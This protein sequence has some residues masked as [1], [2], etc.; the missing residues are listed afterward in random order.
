M[1]AYVFWHVAAAGTG[2]EDYETRL[3][4]FHAALRDDPSPG[5]GATAT[6]GLRSVP[7]LGD[8]GG[9]EDWYLVEDWAALGTLNERAVAAP[10]L[11]PHDAVAGRA[12]A[13]AG[14]VFLLTGG[15]PDFG[16]VAAATF[17]SSSSVQSMAAAAA[18]W[19]MWGALMNR[20]CAR[21]STGRTRSSGSS[22]QPMRQPVMLQYLLKLFTTTAEGLYAA[23]LTSGTSP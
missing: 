2:R 4:G 6:F 3:A 7:W 5:L 16:A 12:D 1:L 17:S 19:A 23:A 10:H 9:Y 22:S 18:T 15:T 21:H 11:V 20:F 13:G 14:A 8:R